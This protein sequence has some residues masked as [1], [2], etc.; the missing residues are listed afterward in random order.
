MGGVYRLKTGTNYLCSCPDSSVFASTDFDANDYANA[1]LAGEPYPP[2]P[3]APR[4]SKPPGIIDTAREDISV[5][6]GK[7]DTG[8]ED[9]SK[10]IK[11]V[12]RLASLAS[13]LFRVR[14][15]LQPG[16]SPCTMKSCWCRLQ[17][18]VTLRARSGRCT[19]GWTS[20]TRP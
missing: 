11:N 12:V 5:A 10:Q 9:V 16:R 17:A 20:W 2:Q 7:L 1:I 3:G 19:L 8:I 4:V 15:D 6:I 13:N 14:R 18:S